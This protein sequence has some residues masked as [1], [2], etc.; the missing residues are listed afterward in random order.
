MQ[1]NK[2]EILE[3]LLVCLSAFAPHMTEELWHQLGH[4]TSVT[5]AIFPEFKAEYVTEDTFEYPVSFNGKMRF[6]MS[7]ALNI[8]VPEIEKQVMSGTETQKWLEGKTPKK[9][10]IVPGKIV[11][12]VI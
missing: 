1:C 12:I 2:R 8:P 10:I 5:K 7:I 6:K 9:V 3:P 4:E 11:N